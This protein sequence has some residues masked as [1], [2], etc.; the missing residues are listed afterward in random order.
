MT[1]HIVS[2]HTF[3]G[4]SEVDLKNIVYSLDNKNSPDCIDAKLLKNIYPSI[5][6]PLINLVNCSL[7]QGIFPDLL[8]ISTII[9]FF[10]KNL[11]VQ[12]HLIFAL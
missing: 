11:S 2:F 12:M 1:T 9:P 6:G 10:K 8:K 4:I 7:E 3:K 5:K